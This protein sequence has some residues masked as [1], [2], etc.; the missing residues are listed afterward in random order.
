MGGSKE[1]YDRFY[2]WW[3]NTVKPQMKNSDYDNLE[4][5]KLDEVDKDGERILAKYVKIPFEYLNDK[6]TNVY[7]MHGAGG[8]PTFYKYKN[9]KM[10]KISG[11]PLARASRNKRRRS[12]SDRELDTSEFTSQFHTV[13]TFESHAV[14]NKQVERAENVI[15]RDNE[16]V[17]CEE[18]PMEEMPN[19]ESDKGISREVT[20]PEP[21]GTV[22]R[23]EMPNESTEPIARDIHRPKFVMNEAMMLELVNHPIFID[24]V[25]RQISEI[26]K[27]L[28]ERR[29]ETYV[30]RGNDRVQKRESPGL[31]SWN[32]LLPNRKH[33]NDVKKCYY[34]PIEVYQSSEIK[35]NSELT[36]A[37]K[38]S[39]ET[40]FYAVCQSCRLKP[41]ESSFTFF[42]HNNRIE[43]CAICKNTQTSNTIG[44]LPICSTCKTASVDKNID[45]DWSKSLLVRLIEVVRH[46]F[47]DLNITYH[48]ELKAKN[49]NASGQGNWNKRCDFVIS[50]GLK[51]K[52]NGRQV[53]K[54][55]VI[56]IELDKEQKTNI[57][58]ADTM[59][60][61]KETIKL[62]VKE[63]NSQ[64][65][66]NVLGIW[67]VNHDGKFKTRHTT[68]NE[69]DMFMR[70]VI[71]RQWVYFVIYNWDKLPKQYVWYFWYD[72]DRLT[73]LRDLWK[74][75][76]L[77]TS[78]RNVHI[79]Q[80]PPD[81][82]NHSWIYCCDPTEGGTIYKSF[83]KKSKKGGGEAREKRDDKYKNPYQRG[84][85]EMR[86]TPEKIFGEFPFKD[87]DNEFPILRV[88]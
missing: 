33:D 30:L 60:D 55:I 9:G 39:T 77:D 12:G 65:K 87:L 59:K 11:H 78:V 1:V 71:L 8:T 58:D 43:V 29:S 25:E 22:D 13:D 56:L 5:V 6:V 3:E 62:K 14:P 44:T 2:N 42:N 31:C 70:M 66:P 23:A 75:N 32:K 86:A 37:T 64:F 72:Q 26:L 51:V 48:P 83:D 46:Q 69:V 84:I 63:I 41:E 68:V 21:N 45:K 61:I 49:D 4:V 20:D 10:E 82:A 40:S 67:K 57:T 7:R 73:R 80:E 28:P 27:K 34:V 16:V 85:V 36:D 53:D 52:E 35:D 24:A 79:I 81:D 18:M 74:L 19:M 54:S 17:P 15:I 88:E 38:A 50:F 47:Y 76:V